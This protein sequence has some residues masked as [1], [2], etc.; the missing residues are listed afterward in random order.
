VEHDAAKLSALS[1]VV[2]QRQ[3]TDDTTYATIEVSPQLFGSCDIE[4]DVVRWRA[5]R[6]SAGIWQKLEG[7]KNRGPVQAL[8][9]APLEE[10]V[11]TGLAMGV[12]QR[13]HLPKT[14]RGFGFGQEISSKVPT[15][16]GLL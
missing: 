7:N 3:S 12:F 14:N 5:F 4:T 10:N 8:L 15:F 2:R 11:S 9:Y 13:R 6:P 1:L 16:V